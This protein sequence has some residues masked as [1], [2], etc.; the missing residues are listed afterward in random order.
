MIRPT[1]QTVPCR[2]YLSG[3]PNGESDTVTPEVPVL[4]HWNGLPA[5]RLWA[6]PES[7]EHLVLG[8]AA[9]DMCDENQVPVIQNY[10]EYDFHLAPDFRIPPEPGQRPEPLA[11]RIIPNIMDNFIS[12]GGHWEGTGCFHKAALFDPG[13]DDFIHVTEDIGRHNCI[14]RLKGW[15]LA[16]GRDIRSL[17]LFVSARCTAS[18]AE[19]CV[20]LGVAGVVSRSAVTVSAIGM[21]EEAGMTLAGF[22]RKDR[23]TV[24]TDPSGLIEEEPERSLT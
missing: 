10:L 12:S 19:K 6:F 9:L 3:K 14:D 11:C 20:R 17:W 2:R 23:F 7:L 4:I 1:M 15:S 18:L 8:H 22:A 16:Q 13:A 5:R 21:A 24:F